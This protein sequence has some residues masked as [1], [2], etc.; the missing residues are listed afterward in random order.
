MNSWLILS[1]GVVYIYV[2]VESFVKGDF[3]VGVT[4][5]GFSIGNVGLFLQA[6]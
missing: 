2:A 3:N 6:R 1:I 5:V 4:F